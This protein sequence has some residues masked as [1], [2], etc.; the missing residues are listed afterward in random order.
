M[1]D[2]ATL[3]SDFEQFDTDG[4]GTID[5]A[6]FASL[7]DFLGVEF[8][9]QQIDVAFHAIDDDKSGKIEFQEFSEWWQKYQAG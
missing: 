2:E 9:S 4:N 6:E 1:S 8:S 5:R 3:R 7:L